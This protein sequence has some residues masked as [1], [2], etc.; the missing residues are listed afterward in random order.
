M[1][2]A[3]Y[4]P[5]QVLPLFSRNFIRLLHNHTI[6]STVGEKSHYTFYTFNKSWL[7]KHIHYSF[8]TNNHHWYRVVRY[9]RAGGMAKDEANVQG[10]W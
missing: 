10:E 4:E 8:H 2:H 7:I 5:P 9:M 3:S 6:H 1:D